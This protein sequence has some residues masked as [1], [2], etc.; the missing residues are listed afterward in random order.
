MLFELNNSKI[1]P[2][3]IY[4]KMEK[5]ILLPP[6]SSSKNSVLVNNYPK[7]NPTSLPNENTKINYNSLNP[8]LGD[9]LKTVKN[10]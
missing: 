2:H 9:F 7:E 8:T 4:N 1:I 6:L 5:G 3:S 10:N